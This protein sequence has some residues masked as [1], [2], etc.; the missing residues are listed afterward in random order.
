MTKIIGWLGVLAVIAFF[1][2]KLIAAYNTD[3]ARLA[4]SGGN[5]EP[6]DE[7]RFETELKAFQDVGDSGNDFVDQKRFAQAYVPWCHDYFDDGEHTGWVGSVD[8]VSKNE[9][10]AAAIFIRTPHGITL[11]STFPT[12]TKQY[13]IASGLV[14]YNGVRFSFRTHA[15]PSAQIN[16]DQPP[17]YGTWTED[18]QSD[19]G[20]LLT[21]SDIY[22]I[23]R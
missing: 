13:Q 18:N 7:V 14:K 8:A 11:G 10:G 23:S 2:V 9:D 17:D 6:P 15:D 12:S 16:C 22:S 4:V 20:S 21:Y 3:E 5:A 1:G 19:R